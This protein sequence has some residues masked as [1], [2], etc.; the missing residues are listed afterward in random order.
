M[1]LF[2]QKSLGT[3]GLFYKYLF[4]I[5]IVVFDCVANIYVIDRR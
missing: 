2:K 1:C 4:L 3:V 5:D